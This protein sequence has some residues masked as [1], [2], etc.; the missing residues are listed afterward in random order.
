MKSRARILTLALAVS[1]LVP[2]AAR[3]EEAQP[4]PLALG[5]PVPMIETKMKNVDGRDLSI[6][7]IAGKK[8]TLVVFSCNACPWAKAWETRIVE[9]GN[10][11]SKRGIGTI[12]INSNDPSRAAEDDYT[13]MQARAKQRGMKYP[14]VVD[15]TSDV[16]RAFGATRT[17]EVFLFDAA[18]KLAYHGAVDDNAKEPKK[19]KERYLV[20]AL[21]AV[22]AGRPVAMKETKS[23][24][25]TIKF[26][27]KA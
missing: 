9:I 24:G 15:E 23:L 1:A 12:V 4:Q 20:S 22:A 7:D 11:W 26:R 3:A 8:G 13:T 10:Q 25:C 16:A 17:P 21:Q 18:G 6:A 2:I 19:V 27:P 5:S 14:Y